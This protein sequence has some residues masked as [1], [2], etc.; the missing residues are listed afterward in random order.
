MSRAD[1][2]LDTL[3]EDDVSVFTVKPHIVINSDRTITVP[4]SLKRIAVQYDH[5]IETITFDCPR[6]WDELDR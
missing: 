6:Y 1:E 5:N 4:N 3:S 2:L